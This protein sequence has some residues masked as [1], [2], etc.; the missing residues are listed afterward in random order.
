M[1]SAEKE[2]GLAQM[3]SERLLGLYYLCAQDIGKRIG[4]VSDVD[5]QESARYGQEI[6]RRMKA[7]NNG[8]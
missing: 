3:S 6:L 2:Q 5:R 1:I 8:K 4:S 7:G